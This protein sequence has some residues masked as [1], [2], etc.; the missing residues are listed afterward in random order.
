MILHSIK[1]LNTKHNSE[2]NLDRFKTTKLDLDSIHISNQTFKI[3]SFS[4]RKG[5]KMIDPNNDTIIQAKKTFLS[6]LKKNK[7]EKSG[8]NLSFSSISLLANLKSKIRRKK[9]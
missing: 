6:F 2:E 5:S 7:K 8:T 3:K 1:N 4:P 9:R